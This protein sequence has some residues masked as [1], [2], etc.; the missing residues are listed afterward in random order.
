M[1]NTPHILSAFL[2]LFF[3]SACKP[4]GSQRPVVSIEGNGFLIDGVPTYEGR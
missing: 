1:K 3:F 2:M 4:S